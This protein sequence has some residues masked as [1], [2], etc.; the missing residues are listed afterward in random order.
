[1]NAADP[2]ARAGVLALALLLV[3]AAAAAE[4][5]D[6]SSWVCEYC[7]F[8]TGHRAEYEAGLSHASDDAARFGDARGYESEGA[9]VE[10]SG[11][12]SYVTDAHQLR[13]LAEDLG[14]DSR[15]LVISGG[16]QGRYSYD[17]DYRQLPQHLFDTTAT[18]FSETS[19][20]GLSLPAGWVF[21]PTTDGFT[22]LDS[23]LAAR[24]ISSRR[25]VLEIAGSYLP[26]DRFRVSASYRR[27]QRDGVDIRG[28][29]YFTQSSLLPAPFE[30]ATDEAELSVR[31]ATDTALLKLGYFGSF[32]QNDN[33][34]LR[35]QTPF[36]SAP[37]AETGAMARA[38]DN[39]FQQI[40]LAGSWAI[41]GADTV[42][43]FNAASGQMRQDDVLLPYTSNPSLATEPLPRSRL[44]GEVDTANLAVALKARPTDRL[45]LKV[46]YR[47]D[48]RDNRT[49]VDF[50]NRVIVDTFNSGETEAN[51]PYSFRKVHVSADGRYQLFDN[52]QISAGVDRIEKDRDFQ[53]VAEQTEDS[54][55]GMLSWR[56]NAY[57]DIRA[58]GGSSERDI[59]RYDEDVAISLG[60]NPLLRK[61]NL[62]YRF[63]RFGE[64][65]LAASV[66]DKPL[67]LTL[68]A[69]Y[70][71]DEYTQSR[72]GLTGS[73]DL[74]IAGDL[75][76]PLSDDRYFYLHGGYESMESDQRGSEQFATPDWSAR[77]TDDFH[78]FGGGFVWRKIRD[79]IDLTFDYTRA[80]GT[81]EISVASQAPGISRF[82]DLE[83]TLD[84]LRLRISWRRSERLSLNAGL[85]YEG[86]TVEDW[87][88][89][90]VMPD[91]LPVI[92]TLGA[93]PYDYD[94]LLAR[95]SFTYGIGDAATD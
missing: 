84:S 90:G 62:A 59:D 3:A 57:V 66:P 1:M 32:F 63:R 26:L 51:V 95:V 61:Y 15:H 94:V 83:S 18:I 73:D 46:A 35:W 75:S 88:L 27:Q 17:I 16:D 28:G 37:G 34:A 74:R 45:R 12:G 89:A 23:S 33:S 92:L 10:L 70:A 31:Y 81:T 64:L 58:R 24:D 53:E 91:T 41:R 93:E 6:T 82:P 60:Q 87:A 52:V 50:W 11:R 13:W 25:R 39:A 71:R 77:N 65:T 8:E 44:D 72:L 80:I 56:P 68:S 36:T 47:L 69:M 2:F 48:D 76:V 29:S 38:P 78:T 22:S 40:S 42:L 49:S 14:L 20:A 7:P 30:Y 4:V 54:G 85:H 21:A 67:S 55:W 79:T 43:T 19:D 9:Y 5:P 86:F